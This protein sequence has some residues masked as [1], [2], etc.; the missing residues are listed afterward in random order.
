MSIDVSALLSVVSSPTGAEKLSSAGL[1]DGVWTAEFAKALNEQLASLQQNAQRVSLSKLRGIDLLPETAAATG[2]NLPVVD[3]QANIDLQATLQALSEILKTIPATSPSV[4]EIVQPAAS[5]DN[6]E[7]SQEETVVPLVVMPVNQTGTNAVEASSLSQQNATQ[8]NASEITNAS[9]TLNQNASD[10]AVINAM[11]PNEQ[12]SSLDVDADNEGLADADETN[13]ARLLD[14][15]KDGNGTQ[16]M[17]L[18]KIM[19]DVPQVNRVSGHESKAELVPMERHFAH[20]QWDNELS[21][22]LV[23]MHKQNVPSAEL[24]LNPRHLGPISVRID[25][26]H[27]QTSVAF[28]A[29]HAVVKDAIEAAIPKLR[30]M[31]GTQQLN[32]VNVDV[33]QQ[34]SGQRQGNDFFQMSEQQAS[35]SG[36]EKISQNQEPLSITEEIEAGRAIAS[37]GILSIF[38]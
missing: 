2:K 38:A 19:A 10:G 22:K 24:N 25:V 17:G 21:E 14:N 11:P 37:Q 1:Q 13:F 6:S 18:P 15:K 9:I 30:D 34:Q 27:D 23:W 28:T 8:N 5:D 33:S 26:N 35:E 3:K 4:E 20:P 12:E 32:L 7:S 36:D 16:E 29:H 31:L